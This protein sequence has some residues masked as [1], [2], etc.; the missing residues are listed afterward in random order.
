M[1]KR[2]AWTP[3]DGDIKLIER[4]WLVTNGRGGYASSTLAGAATRRYHGL[5]IAALPAPLGRT[6]MLNHLSEELRFPDGQVVQI[7]CHEYPE[8]LHLACNTLMQE[9]ALED[10]LPVWRFAVNG[11]LIEKRLLMPHTQDPPRSRALERCQATRSVATRPSG[12]A[13]PW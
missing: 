9:F 3:A 2:V 11:T 5:L 10:G 12:T 13:A 8:H 1:I 4:E 6:V 7:G